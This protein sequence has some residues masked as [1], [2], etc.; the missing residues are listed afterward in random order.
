[1]KEGKGQQMSGG[2]GLA[3]TP[4]PG[5]GIPNTADKM[6]LP[7]IPRFHVYCGH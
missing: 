3:A 6:I 4:V 1:M 5:I 7:E 2:G